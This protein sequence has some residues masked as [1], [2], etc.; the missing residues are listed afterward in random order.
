VKERALAEPW[1]ITDKMLAYLVERAD[2]LADRADS[3]R[4]EAELERVVN[5]IEAYEAER[6]PQG[7]VVGGKG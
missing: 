3:P 2:Q 1:D 7:K 5:M 6:W 4:A